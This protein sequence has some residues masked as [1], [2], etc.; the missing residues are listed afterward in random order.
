[1]FGYERRMIRALLLPL[2]GAVLLGCAGTRERPSNAQPESERAV[3]SLIAAFNAHDAERMLEHVSPEIE[4]LNVKGA[5]VTVQTRGSEALGKAM[6]EYFAAVKNAH[7]E[8]E[9]LFVNGRFVSV[10]ERASWDG[11]S[12]RRSGRAIGIYEVEGGRIVRV[13][14]FPPQP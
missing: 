14:Y 8:L 11:K 1:V 10:R 6:R 7:S 13:W 5:T 2:V 12:G 9:E 4:W 3:R